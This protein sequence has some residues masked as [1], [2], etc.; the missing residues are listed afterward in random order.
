MSSRF[1]ADEVRRSETSFSLSALLVAIAWVVPA[2]ASL[3]CVPIVARGLGSQ[4]YGLLVLVTAVSGYLGLMDLGLGQAIVR[5]LAFYRARNEGRPMVAVLRVAL[6]WF[7]G[8]GVVG[9]VAC[10]VAAPWLVESVLDV[11]DGLSSEGVLAIRL[12]AVAFAAGMVMGVLAQV[13][14]GF[15]RYDL[16]AGMTLVVGTTAAIG[17]AILVSAGSGL[18]SLVGFA[19]ALNFAAAL[20]YGLIALRLLR[21]VD[22]RQG[23]GWAGIR[24]Q[25]LPFVG[26]TALSRAHTV[27]AAQSTR[28]VVGI[29]AGTAAAAYYQIPNV[30]S[31]RIG[32][33]LSRVA[34]ILFPTAS[35]LWATGEADA[36]R[37][38]YL[39]TSR[40]FFIANAAVGAA[41]FAMAK[42][43]LTHWLNDEFAAA[44]TYA[45]AVF[46]V[47]QTVNASTQAASYVNLS[48]EKPGINLTF[49]AAN[50]AV[51]LL[52]VY[53]LV[54][55]LGVTGAALAGLC[56]CLTVPFFFRHTHRRVLHLGS[57]RVLRECYLT[58]A[59]LAV[60]VAVFG[61]LI[62]APRM[63][64]LLTTLGAWATLVGLVVL[65][66]GVTGVIRREDVR[67]GQHALRG[68]RVILLRR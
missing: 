13:P 63:H 8:V 67:S 33:M 28:L 9:G 4:T 53:P 56:A 68:L 18:V 2:V 61:W 52:T 43:L 40:M 21:T 34:Q 55:W 27:A 65:L 57:W 10:Y 38:L 14:Q 5:Y 16:V 3:V 50:S 45:L 44:G 15:L 25:V 64:S 24:R 7:F 26:I 47:S 35:G 60:S 41:T 17:P 20:F 31:G 32:E 37:H 48:A 42:P 59:A 11:P 58:S 46:A 29:A 23:P 6:L 39:R 19:L 36:V 30:L 12:S 51:T 1:S 66:G 62:V 22:R 54:L 49:S